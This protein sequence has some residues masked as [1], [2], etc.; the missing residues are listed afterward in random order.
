MENAIK[1]LDVRKHLPLA[2]M[3]I[4]VNGLK[5]T[6]D[7][8]GH[9]TGDQLLK[10]VA[11]L[12][13]KTC[14]YDNVIGRMGGDEFCVIM[15][16]TDE[17]RADTVVAGIKETAAALKLMP[18]IVSLAVGYAVKHSPDQDIKSVMMTADNLMYKDKIKNGRAVRSQTIDMILGSINLNY[19]QEQ[20]HTER[21]S[22]FSE[23]IA[24]AMNLSDR[25]I[26]DIKTAGELHD[27][28]KIMVPPQ[29]LNKPG[30]LTREEFELIKRHPEI[31]YQMLKSV[32]EYAHLSEYI[33]YHHERYDGSGYPEGLTGTSIPLYARII[34]VADAFEAMTAPR[35]YQKTKTIEE[36][37]EE[38]TR[39]AGKQFDADIVSI[40]ISQ[41]L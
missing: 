18:I 20:I 14:R 6:N 19:S 11:E 36:A 15:P 28:G 9:E 33:L 24:R 5:L 38:L 16:N 30:K 40:F 7:A 2:L 23:S 32:D 29:L 37:V 35:P 41:V 3:V 10:Q 17:T 34:A 13:N 1:K 27:I 12:L 22:Q 4:D 31:G 8:F 21:V 26:K 39:C 25:E